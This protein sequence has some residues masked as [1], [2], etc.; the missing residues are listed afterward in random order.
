MSPKGN[1]IT[2]RAK[3]GAMSASEA[4]TFSPARPSMRDRARWPRSKR[5]SA[6]V[7]ACV[8]F[9]RPL[10]VAGIAGDLGIKDEQAFLEFGNLRANLFPVDFQHLP[11]GWPSSVA[12]VTKRRVTQHVPDWHSCGLEPIEECDPCEDRCV[13]ITLAGAIPVN[14][15]QQPDALIV[16][17]RVSRQAGSFCEVADLHVCPFSY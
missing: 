3:S 12:F 14:V 16:T 9:L 10:F 1:S 4:T 7:W 15:W 13:I 11:P 6:C 8:I 5:L 2:Y 17:Q